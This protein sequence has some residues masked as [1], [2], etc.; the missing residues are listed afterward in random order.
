VVKKGEKTSI[1]DSVLNLKRKAVFADCRR[2]LKGVYFHTLRELEKLEEM[3]D[4]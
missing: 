1:P 2:R 4:N 3:F